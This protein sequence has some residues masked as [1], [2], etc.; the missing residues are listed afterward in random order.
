[1]ALADGGELIVLAP[2]VERFGEDASMDGLIRRYGYR[3][4]AYVLER[5][6]GE[7]ALRGNLAAAAHLIH[8]SSDGRV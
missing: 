6:E 4:R 2:G 1:M 7:E 3:G 5:V 8:G